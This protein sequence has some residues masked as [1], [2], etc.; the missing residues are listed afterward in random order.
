MQK[1]FRRQ[2]SSGFTLAEVAVTLVIA[3]IGLVLILQGLNTAR[4]EVAHTS[5]RKTARQLA[6]LTLGQVEAGLFWEEGEDI[7]RL[8][9]NYE[10]EGYPEYTWEIVLGDDNFSNET[11][12]T[13]EFDTYRHRQEVEDERRAEEDSDDEDEEDVEEPF[14]KVRV[15]VIFPKLGEWENFI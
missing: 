2:S 13:L 10:E 9:G 14:E 15:R 8:D 6:M 1:S 5:F 11:D 7:D 12:P 3:G 4:S